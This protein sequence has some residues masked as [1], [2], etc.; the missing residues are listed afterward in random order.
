MKG[1]WLL[2]KSRRWPSDVDRISTWTLVWVER[3]YLAN[4]NV[5]T[6]DAEASIS[7]L[8]PLAGQPVMR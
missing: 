5:F 7:L 4:E 3:V 6:N 8:S 2:F 1:S